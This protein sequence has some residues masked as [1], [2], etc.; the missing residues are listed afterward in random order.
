MALVLQ[1]GKLLPHA[2][3]G[4]CCM[5]LLLLLLVVLLLLLLLLV[6][7][8]LL[9]LLLQTVP[10]LQLLLLSGLV[11]NKHQQGQGAM[12]LLSIHTS[13]SGAKGGCYAAF[14]QGLV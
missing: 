3:L 14:Q 9:L 11:V 1:G 10:R 7:L 5:L 4:N 2:G 8:L 12:S 13:Q 6:V